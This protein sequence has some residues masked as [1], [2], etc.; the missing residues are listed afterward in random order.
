LRR[1]DLEKNSME[2]AIE[3]VNAGNKE[4]AIRY[5]QDMSKNW[6]VLHDRYVAWGQI[7]LNFIAVRVGEDAVEEAHKAITDY[8]YGPMFGK[9]NT[10]PHEEIV[11]NFVRMSDPHQHKY[12]VDEDEEKTVITLDLCGSGGRAKKEGV[13][14]KIGGFTKEPYDWAFGREGM[15]YYCS[16]CRVHEMIWEKMDFPVDHVY[17]DIEKGQP[18]KWV[19]QKR[20]LAEPTSAPGP[21]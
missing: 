7:L 4:E 18:C 16:H 2:R 13:F 15:P 10:Q 9:W 12:H 21:K 6:M 1:P 8:V 17:G 11:A 5:I 19:I 3:A 20:K 14:K